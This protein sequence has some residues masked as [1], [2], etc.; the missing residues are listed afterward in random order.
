MVESN[1]G[2]T[3]GSLGSKVFEDGFDRKDKIRADLKWFQWEIYYDAEVQWKSI[4][5]TMVEE[6][7][8]GIDLI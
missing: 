2:G 8:F 6:A 1:S 5:Q 4:G 3:G 7:E